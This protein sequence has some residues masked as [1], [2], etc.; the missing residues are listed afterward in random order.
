MFD[1][2]SRYAK[3]EAYIVPDRR[4]RAVT[5]VAVPPKPGQDLL[6][7]HA[8]REGERLDHL[9]Q[10]YLDDATTYWA[11]AEQNDVMLAESLAERREIDI[12]AKQ[13]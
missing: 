12:P 8:L 1:S 4:G 11:I 10:T 7:I 6:G 3:T 5:V 9:A 2:N 13:N